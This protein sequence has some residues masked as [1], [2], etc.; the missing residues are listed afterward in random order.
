MSNPAAHPTPEEARAQLALSASKR[1]EVTRRDRVIVAVSIAGTGLAMAIY[2]VWVVPLQRASDNHQIL[3]ACLFAVPLMASA[4][5]ARASA[6]HHATR[7]G[8]P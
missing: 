4:S 7:S 5:S 6:R 1:P 2:L 3:F 8:W